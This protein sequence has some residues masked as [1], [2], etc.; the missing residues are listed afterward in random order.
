MIYSLS[1]TRDFAKG[2]V[3]DC[4]NADV[5]GFNCCFT[6]ALTFEH[7]IMKMAR[8]FIYG[9]LRGTLYCF[10]CV[11]SLVES[12]TDAYYPRSCIG[13]ENIYWTAFR[14]FTL[15]GSSINLPQKQCRM[16][17]VW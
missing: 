3:C 7:H 1:T 15:R 4:L 2:G 10:Q 6:N 17:D 13:F 12:W 5:Q 11:L 14:A 9:A 8:Q 16:G